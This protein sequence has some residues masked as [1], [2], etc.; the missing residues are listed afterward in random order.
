MQTA[1][2]ASSNCPFKVTYIKQHSEGFYK[3]SREIQDTQIKHNH[4][5]PL[6]NECFYQN[7][8]TSGKSSFV[9]STPQDQSIADEQNKILQAIFKKDKVGNVK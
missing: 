7:T 9:K 4:K 3:I 6:E 8:N 2:K 1:K 5:L